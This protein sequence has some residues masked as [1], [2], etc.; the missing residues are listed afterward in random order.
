MRKLVE[1]EGWWELGISGE[2]CQSKTGLGLWVVVGYRQSR[3]DL[4]PLRQTPAWQFLAEDAIRLGTGLGE[5]IVRGVVGDDG[6]SRW[7][8][9]FWFR[10]GG[11][12]RE[13]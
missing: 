11:L 10:L 9:F 8:F 4:V 1:E 6:V 13:G 12:V 5:E 2:F 7:L 3:L